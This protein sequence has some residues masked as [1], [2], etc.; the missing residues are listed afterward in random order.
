MY[1]RYRVGTF[2]SLRLY[3]GGEGWISGAD[4]LGKADA[5]D[6]ALELVTAEVEEEIIERTGRYSV[7][8]RCV[9]RG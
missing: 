7:P 9:V 4:D 1:S 8:E 3:E 6:E 5:L 2:A